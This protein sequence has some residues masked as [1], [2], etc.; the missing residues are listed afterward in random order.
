MNANARGWAAAG[1]V[2]IAVV[3]ALGWY[4]VDAKGRA[5]R[6]AAAARAAHAAAG[7]GTDDVVG[8]EAR[9]GDA[10]VEPRLPQSEVHV[11]DPLVRPVPT[12]VPGTVTVETGDPRV[13][14]WELAFP[15]GVWSL[16]FVLGSPDVALQFLDLSG[17]VSADCHGLSAITERGPAP[18]PN[19]RFDAATHTAQ[20][21]DMPLEVV[22]ALTRARELTL[23]ACDTR[24]T[25][26]DTQQR[27]LIEFYVQTAGVI[28]DGVSAD[29]GAALETP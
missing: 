7:G 29:A 17:T 16:R 6:A 5:D 22:E 28:L 11:L 8:D 23:V 4:I 27:K 19:A 13:V 9:Q 3:A 26:D 12:A 25:L 15:R 14:T 20:L 10:H 2:S 18:F 24:F 1:V 21:S